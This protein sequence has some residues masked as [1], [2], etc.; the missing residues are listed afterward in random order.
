[1]WTA[2]TYTNCALKSDEK[3]ST[4]HLRIQS[5][6]RSIGSRAS[7]SHIQFKTLLMKV[8]KSFPNPPKT[9]NVCKTTSVRW[10]LTTNHPETTAASKGKLSSKFE[11]DITIT[12]VE[13]NKIIL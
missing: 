2:N 9:I 7:S 11:D 5:K 12:E 1:M 3:W 13:G 10:R 8:Q 6:T 4:K